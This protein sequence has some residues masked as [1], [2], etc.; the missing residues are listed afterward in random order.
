MRATRVLFILCG[1][2]ATM[3]AWADMSGTYV[4]KSPTSAIMIQIVE[5]SGGNFTGRFEQVALQANGQIEDINATITGASNGETVVATIK[6]TGFLTTSTPVSGTF[7]GGVLH[8]TGGT[9]LILDLSKTTEADFRTQVVT[10][11]AQGQQVIAARTRQE[12][13]VK[14]AKLEADRRAKL[15]SL[16]GR[17]IT[18]TTKADAM[19]PKFG[20]EA[21]KYRAITERMRGGLARQRTI[22]GGGQASADRSQILVDLNQLAI[23]ANQIHLDDQQWYRDFDFNAGQLGREAA[24]ANMWCQGPIPVSFNGVCPQFL[25]AQT[26]FVKRV[27]ALRAA[28]ADLEATWN[29][30]RREQEAIV[31]ASQQAIR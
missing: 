19:L 4:G 20:P 6:T 29:T 11:T 9:N 15:Q 21:Q 10:L 24:D 30:E 31:Q 1:L 14:Q 8:L 26:G 27:S 17:L 22:R 7:R 23:D 3:P 2:L 16:T 25:D 13:E 28:F 18:F 12:A 5:T